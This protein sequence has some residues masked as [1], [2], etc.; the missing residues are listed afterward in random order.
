MSELTR[1]QNL[2]FRI[3][4]KSDEEIADIIKPLET[5]YAQ[6][7]KLKQKPTTYLSVMKYLIYLYDPGTDLNRDFV[8]LE[9]RKQEAAKLSGL[10]LIKDLSYLDRIFANTLPEVL[11]V[12]QILLSE[13]Y[14]DIDYREWHTLNE[15]LDE[16][17]AAR[18]EKIESKR[19]KGRKGDDEIMEI[20]G[21][22]KSTMETLTLKSKLREDCKR[23]R[24]L[25]GE[26]NTKIFG[27]NKDIQE[28]AYKSRFTNPESF[29][30]AKQQVL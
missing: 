13:I 12:I 27:E 20:T 7:R 21:A 4:G 1:Y 19:K 30:R 24:E 22:T 17:T 2:K 15:E 11:D 3:Y 29:S 18:W 5:R 26:L 10:L 25:L 14:H 28:L 6:V 23:I 9:D 16:Y 8:R